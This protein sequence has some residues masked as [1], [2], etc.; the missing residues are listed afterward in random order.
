MLQALQQLGPAQQNGK[1]I[2][3]LL[4]KVRTDSV[5]DTVTNLQQQVDP[6]RQLQE[7]GQQQNRGTDPRPNHPQ[8]N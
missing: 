3:Q 7:Q 1:T 2:S 5:Q 6:Q 4:P 8:G